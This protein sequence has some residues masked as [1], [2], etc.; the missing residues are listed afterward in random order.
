MASGALTDWGATDLREQFSIDFGERRTFNAHPYDRRFYRCECIQ[1]AELQRRFARVFDRV[2]HDEPGEIAQQQLR[3]HFFDDAHRRVGA[4][5]GDFKPVFPFAVNRFD[6]P[7][8]V[9]KRNQF[10]GGKL[11]RVEQRG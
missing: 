8:A 3:V 7:A 10:R 4:Q 1:K 11:N 5:V 9:I 2:G 6:A